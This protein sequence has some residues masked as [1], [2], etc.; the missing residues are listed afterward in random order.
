[1]TG[2]IP[3]GELHALVRQA[4]DMGSL[5]ERRSEASHVGPTQIIDQKEYD[6]RLRFF[7]RAKGKTPQKGS[8]E[9]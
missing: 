2:G 8:K 5:I 3:G 7:L 9:K 6:V 4:V 1:M